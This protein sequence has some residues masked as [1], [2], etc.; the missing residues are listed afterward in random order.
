[1]QTFSGSRGTKGSAK[2]SVLSKMERESTDTIFRGE[3]SRVPAQQLEKLAGRG[4]AYT[5]RLV[6]PE[7]ASFVRLRLLLRRVTRD[8][9]PLTSNVLRRAWLVRSSREMRAQPLVISTSR[10]AALPTIR[11]T[12]GGEHRVQPLIHEL[13]LASHQGHLF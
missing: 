12:P 10:W 9:Q 4:A 11:S 6:Q 3:R 13:S 7:A 1:M 5:L 8:W 2:F